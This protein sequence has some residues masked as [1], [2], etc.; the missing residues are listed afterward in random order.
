MAGAC[1]APLPEEPGR[2]SASLSPFDPGK[3]HVPMPGTPSSMALE[4]LSLLPA[5]LHRCPCP[6]PRQKRMQE[7]LRGA[8]PQSFPPVLAWGHA[9][10]ALHGEVGTRSRAWGDAQAAPMPAPRVRKPQGNSS[11]ALDTL[12]SSSSRE[13]P[14][15]PKGEALCSGRERHFG[16]SC[17]CRSPSPP[18]V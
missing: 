2:I 8:R 7:P 3:L 14:S 12:K 5:L 10:A 18:W 13:L 16:G 6:F 15:G 9:S 11:G 4:P 1:P 17:V